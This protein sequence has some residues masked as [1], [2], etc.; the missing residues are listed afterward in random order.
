MLS[1]PRPRGRPVAAGAVREHH[2]DAVRELLRQR[3]PHRLVERV[4]HDPHRLGGLLEQ[5][6]QH[7]RVLAGARRQVIVRQAVAVDQL[8]AQV[9]EAS[10]PAD[11]A[12]AVVEQVE[13]RGAAGGERDRQRC[14]AEA[15]V[16]HHVQ[17]GGARR[18]GKLLEPLE[19]PR[20]PDERARRARGLATGPVDVVL[21]LRVASAQQAPLEV[22]R[23][24]RICRGG[25]LVERCAVEDR[26]EHGVAAEL[27]TPDAEQFRRRGC[28]SA[29]VARAGLAT[30]TGRPRGGK[31]RRDRVRAERQRSRQQRRRRGG[32]KVRVEQR[33]VPVRMASGEAALGVG[34]REL[35]GQALRI[36][37]EPRPYLPRSAAAELAFELLEHLHGDVRQCG[38]GHRH[39]P[40]LLGLPA[41]R[42]RSRFVRASAAG[43]GPTARRHRRPPAQL[44][45]RGPAKGAH[46]ER[47]H[48]AGEGGEHAEAEEDHRG[49][50]M[51]VPDLVEVGGVRADEAVTQKGGG[52]RASRGN[53]C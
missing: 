12:L 51:H 44:S 33:C 31:L 27:L 32:K 41:P 19:R 8:G 17:V 15:R 18:A 29:E 2:E 53:A 37:P 46:C 9:V 36:A 10:V 20:S 50:R 25:E 45:K 38:L 7:P 14:L 34:E 16:C 21:Q 47:D 30:D 24:A 48:Q 23:R 3:Q 22:G 5:S 49:L 1:R 43:G 52:V 11:T 35:A 13:R 42:K 40:I 28:D 39:A 6:L 26:P 4:D